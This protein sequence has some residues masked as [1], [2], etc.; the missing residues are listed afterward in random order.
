MNVSPVHLSSGTL[1]HPVCHTTAKNI[2]LSYSQ[3]A[4]AG[5][6]FIHD[7]LQKRSPNVLAELWKVLISGLRRI[8]RETIMRKCMHKTMTDIAAHTQTCVNLH[9]YDDGKTNI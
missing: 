2:R 3:F 8:P 9:N 4:R 1:E 7:S 6:L 5:D